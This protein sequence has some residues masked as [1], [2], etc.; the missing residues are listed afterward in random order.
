MDFEVIINKKQE[1]LTALA[2]LET[3]YFKN[4]ATFKRR[5]ERYKQNVADAEAFNP[6]KG[7]GDY[8]AYKEFLDAHITEVK[9]WDDLI[10]ASKR[11]LEQATLYDKMLLE[12]IGKTAEHIVY[13]NALGI[14]V[15]NG[16][17][18]TGKRIQAEL[19]DGLVTPDNRDKNKNCFAFA[20]GV[21]SYSVS[22][23]GNAFKAGDVYTYGTHITRDL[24]SITRTFENSVFDVSG[25]NENRLY[26]W[27]TEFT[28]LEPCELSREARQAQ[29][30]K[31]ELEALSLQYEKDYKAILS[32]LTT[33]TAYNHAKTHSKP[34]V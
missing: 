27:V 18:L 15:R 9:E 4:V 3:A 20:I 30:V 8:K 22:L 7:T 33:A 24:Y 5:N 6:Y 31:A 11:R 10:T 2:E 14:S 12:T 16:T 21:G 32:R 34:I 1:L 17:K 19:L 13:V 25:D 28:P 29:R 23:H 26:K